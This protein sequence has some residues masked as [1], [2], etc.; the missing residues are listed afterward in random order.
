MKLIKYQ[1]D[2]AATPLDNGVRGERSGYGNQTH[3]LRGDS[4]TVE[5]CGDRPADTQREIAVGGQ[6]FRTGNNRTARVINKR[7]VGIGASCV[8]S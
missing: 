8:N 5:H 3:L 4:A 1:A 6:G 7:G 2:W